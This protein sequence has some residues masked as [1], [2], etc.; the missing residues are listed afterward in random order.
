VPVASLTKDSALIDPLRHALFLAAG[1]IAGR[2]F[3]VE[4][5]LEPLPSLPKIWGTAD[6]IIFDQHERVA[7]IIDLKFGAGIAIEADAIQLQIY[8]LLAAQQYGASPDGITVHIIQPRREHIRGPHRSHHLSTEDLC[9]LVGR[10]VIAVVDSEAL[11][12]P[13][14]AG[15][16][17]RF[18]A[19]AATCPE[20]RNRPP[21]RQRPNDSPWFPSGLPA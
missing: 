8:A 6:V 7:E 12:A 15:S 4:Q 11:N 1:V 16:W 20:Y 13:R 5:K 2:P 14:I 21:V 9:H 3:L 18:C 17:C 10:L 19:A